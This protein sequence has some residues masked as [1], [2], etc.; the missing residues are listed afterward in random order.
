MNAINNYGLQEISAIELQEINGGSEISDML[1]KQFGKAY[2]LICNGVET[3]F[4][5]FAE[6]NSVN[7]SNVAILCK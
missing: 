1:L 2:G 4:E 6:T 7:G 3:T 5:W